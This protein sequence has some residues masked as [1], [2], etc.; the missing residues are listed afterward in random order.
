MNMTVSTVFFIH[1]Y[2][3]FNE[4]G[5][6]IQRPFKGPDLDFEFNGVPN[7]FGGRWYDEFGELINHE[8]F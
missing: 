5:R 2:N 3:Y 4:V 6:D 8:D 1:S 7:G